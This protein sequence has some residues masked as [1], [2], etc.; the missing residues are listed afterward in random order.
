MSQQAQNIV[1]ALTHALQTADPSRRATLAELLRDYEETY[2]GSIGHLSPFSLRLW[3]AIVVGVEKQP[4][5]AS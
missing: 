2:P 4:E 5:E 3:R 1:V